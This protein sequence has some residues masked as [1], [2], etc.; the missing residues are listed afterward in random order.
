MKLSIKQTRA[1]DHLEDLETTELLFG[2]GA[3]GR[4]VSNRVLLDIKVGTQ[5]QRHTVVDW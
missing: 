2:G 3:G 1:L 4:Q 5:V